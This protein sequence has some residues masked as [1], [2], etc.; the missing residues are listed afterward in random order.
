MTNQD[1]FLQYYSQ[2]QNCQTLLFLARLFS[3]T[4]INRSHS[5]YFLTLYL[6]PQWRDLE[7]SLPVPRGM[8]AT[9]GGLPPGQERPSR[10]ERTQPTVPSPPHTAQELR[11]NVTLGITRKHLGVQSVYSVQPQ[12]TELSKHQRE[13]LS[14]NITFFI[15]QFSVQTT[16]DLHSLACIKAMRWIIL[17]VRNRFCC[18]ADKD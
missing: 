10:E 16:L 1:A 2:G 12:V 13:F 5:V 4:S 15:G 17:F 6:P 8:M 18:P 7:R 9:G 14:E 11:L 3:L